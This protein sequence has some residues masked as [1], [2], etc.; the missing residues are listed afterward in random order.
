MNL[1]KT[2]IIGWTSSSFLL[3]MSDDESPLPSGKITLEEASWIA[4]INNIAAFFGNLIFGYITPRYG[5]KIPLLFIAIPNMVRD[6]REKENHGAGQP[7]DA[8]EFV[9]FQISW[10]LILFA[11]NVNYLYASRVLS[12]FVA[13]GIFLMIPLYLKEICIDRVRGTIGSMVVLICNLGIL[14][15]YIFGAYCSYKTSPIFVIASTAT[16]VVAFSFFPETPMFLI[17]Q[18]KLTAAEKSIR[19]Y[20]NLNDSEQHTDLVR[21][22]MTR[23]H[24]MIDN[25]IEKSTMSL[26]RSDFNTKEARNA[27][28]IGMVLILLNKFCGGY[29]MLSYS[30]SVF[31][32]AGSGMTPNK[33]S[34]IVGAIQL[35]GSYVA[36]SL[37]DHAGR[38]VKKSKKITMKTKKK[39]A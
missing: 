11:Q 22:E 15:V 3:L 13:G 20:Q 10:A 29:A 28:T 18:N 21:L 9:V 39:I 17:K 8:I 35:I 1:C 12:G 34:I 30:A 4:G 23:L 5:R 7:I 19:F 31:K 38:K 2:P 26:K 32:E 14:L 24:N 25:S 6:N 33:A 37:V 27:F 36:T 16:F